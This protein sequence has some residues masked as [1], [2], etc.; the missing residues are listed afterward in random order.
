MALAEINTDGFTV[1]TAFAIAVVPSNLEFKIA[2]LYFL[3]QRLSPT[4]APAK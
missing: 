4:P 2:A 3:V 1:A